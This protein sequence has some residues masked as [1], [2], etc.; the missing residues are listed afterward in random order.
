MHCVDD[1]RPTWAQFSG[2]SSSSFIVPFPC[3]AQVGRFPP[4]KLLQLVLST[5]ALSLVQETFKSTSFTA[6]CPSRRQPSSFLGLGPAQWCAGQVVGQGAKMSN[7]LQKRQWSLWISFQN[8]LFQNRLKRCQE[9]VTQNI[10]QNEH[11]YRCDLLPTGSSWWCHFRWTIHAY[12][13][14]NF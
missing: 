5:P 7:R 3:Y 12:A 1:G 8:V 14:L 2:S 11:V 9:I 6:V 4:I 13:V 10:T